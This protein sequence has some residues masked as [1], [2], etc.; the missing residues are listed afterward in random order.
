MKLT[1]CGLEEGGG[2]ERTSQ[3]LY[4]VG[5]SNGGG[6]EGTERSPPPMEEKFIGVK[7]N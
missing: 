2:I 4:A 5:T 7:G 1:L 3:E 6:W